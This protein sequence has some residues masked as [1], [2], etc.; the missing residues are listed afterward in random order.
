M[1]KRIA[2][3][4]MIQLWF[5]GGEDPQVRLVGYSLDDGTTPGIV[6]E[7]TGTP[8]G[9]AAPHTLSAGELSGSMTDFLTGV[10]SAIDSAEG[11]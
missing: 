4:S 3:K 9:Y 11:I 2:A 1:A 7:H 10:T 5:G 8:G 6:Y